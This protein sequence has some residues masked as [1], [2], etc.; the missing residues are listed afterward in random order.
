MQFAVHFLSHLPEFVV[1][2][3]VALIGARL[4]FCQQKLVKERVRDMGIKPK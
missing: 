3:W 1:C 4:P 2:Q